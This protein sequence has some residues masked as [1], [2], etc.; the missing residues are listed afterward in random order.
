MQGLPYK[1]KPKWSF[2]NLFQGTWCQWPDKEPF[3]ILEQGS[4]LIEYTG[5]TEACLKLKNIKTGIKG[6]RE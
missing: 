2:C 3:Y 5:G 6:W 1:K 4:D